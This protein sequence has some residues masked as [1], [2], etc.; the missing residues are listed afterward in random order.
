MDLVQ[1]SNPES[2]DLLRIS[3]F[4]DPDLIPEEILLE[5]LAEVVPQDMSHQARQIT[6][7]E[8]LSVLL[9]FSLI[10]RN[11]ETRTVT[12]HRLV[13]AMIQD[14]MPTEI[15]EQ[16]SKKAVKAVQQAFP[17]PSTIYSAAGHP[18][19]AIQ[20]LSASVYLYREQN[21]RGKLATVLWELAV[22][23]QVIGHLRD[24]E[25]NLMESL[26]LC[27]EIG[28]WFNEAKTRQYLALL[29]IYQGFFSEALSHLDEALALLK[30]HHTKEPRA[31]FV[32]IM[33]FATFMQMKQS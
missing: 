29:R 12:I 6:L 5:I 1:Q 24:A 10:R 33:R 17:Q 32:H 18:H 3:A 8:K 7:N 23:Q 27:Q 16:L 26:A 11:M 19:A 4:L 28:D 9:S 14:T 2:V 25:R 13:Q 15:Q 22:Q 30:E 20:L 31:P 21:S